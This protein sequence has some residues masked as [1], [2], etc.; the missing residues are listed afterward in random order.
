[1][2]KRLICF[3]LGI[4]SGM[5]SAESR[6]LL[7]FQPPAEEARF[8]TLVLEELRPLGNAAG[9][10]HLRL[11]QIPGGWSAEAAADYNERSNNRVDIHALEL[12]GNRLTGDLS[13]QIGPDG[14]RRGRAHFPT[15]ND[16]FRFRFEAELGEEDSEP[17]VDRE[18]FMP[19]WRRDTR[20]FGGRS[21]AGTYEGSWTWKEETVEREGIISGAWTRDPRPGAWGAVGPVWVEVRD[22]F[23]HLRAFLPDVPS[24][25]GVEAWASAA[26]EEAVPFTGAGEIRVRARGNAAEGEAFLSLGLR[27]ERGHFSFVDALPLGEELE[28]IRIDLA[29]FGSPWRPLAGTEL[30]EVRVGIVNGLG[31]G[32]VSAEVHELELLLREAAEPG[33]VT[34]VVR[35]ETAWHF[36]GQSEIPKG[37]FGFHDVGENNPR[38]PREGEPD[39]E[40]MMRIL[41]P[42]SLRP[43]THTGFGGRRL[44]DEDVAAN[45]NLE[46][47]LS[48]PAPDSPF[49][50]RAR[51]GNATDQVVWTHTMDLWARPSW[52]ERGVEAVAA[53]VEVFYRNLASRAWIPGDDENV[54]RYLEVW[55][56]PFMW[57]RHINMGF[58]LTPGDT[59]I[60]DE[61]Q[62]GYIPGKVGS[63]AWSEIFLAAHRGARSV[64]PYVKL[65]GPSAPDFSSHDYQDFVNHTLRILERV[66]AELDFISEHHYGG[67]P[68]TIAAGYEVARSAMW[69]LHRRTIP[70]FNTEANDLGASDAGKATYNLTDI[71][72]LI[73]V[74]P[75]ISLIRALH[76]C[77]NGYLRSQGEIDAYTL[78]ATLRG[79]MIDVLADQDRITV[80]ASTPESGRLVVLGV[81]HGFG[82]VHLR[83][84]MPAGF[85]VEELKLLLTDSPLEE[86]QIRDV[87][88]AE[89]PRPARGQTRLV[90]V[91]PELRGGFL[92]LQLPERSAFRL[93]LSRE[94]YEPSRVRSQQLIPLAHLLQPLRPGESLNLEPEEAVAEPDRLFLRLVHTGE[95]EL[96]VGDRVIPLPAGADRASNALVRDIEVPVTVLSQQPVLRTSGRAKVL[97]ASWIVE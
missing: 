79:I 2:S 95:L 94:G 8:V 48:R 73:R 23:L 87:D 93:T 24:V 75:D 60:T 96:H 88:G 62:F 31:V 64:N 18:A 34:I 81:D 17:F 89:I 3:C 86:L 84:P 9:H 67:N 92:H 65:G 14:A 55:N 40:E 33:L 78:A 91:R 38:A 58:R 6:N 1:M 36:N 21:V 57:G 5:L 43:L 35:P 63:A 10:L 16:H 77:W 27:T 11:R 4:L 25:E 50:R 32:T 37:L 53:D 12:E 80:A 7:S 46:A 47:R 61:T 74:N 85:A 39:A 68:L 66:G 13:V 26:W 72:N 41:N 29:R 52:L 82:S 69:K 70:I 19:S 45:M 20:R 59:D 51:A 83:F 54:L 15:P 30:R 49:H 71:L 56:E 76:A 97:S 28:E 90:A 44:P 22:N 42:G